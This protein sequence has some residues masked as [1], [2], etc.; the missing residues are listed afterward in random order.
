MQQMLQQEQQ[1]YQSLMMDKQLEAQ[2]LQIDQFNAETNRMKAAKEVQ[3]V[4][5]IQ[6][7]TQSD[8]TEAEKMRFD[9][10]VKFAL[11]EQKQ[12]GAIELELVKQRA[13]IAKANTDDMMIAD[14]NL[15]LVPSGNANAIV[16]ALS[17]LSQ[18][19]ADLKRKTSAPKIIIRDEKGRA[20][21]SRIVEDEE[22]DSTDD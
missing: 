15:N 21:G 18:N 22:D 10:E 8:M 4:Q 6:D 16:A 9:A 5:N 2:K 12:K 1:K 11:E 13:D 14:E 7:V 17:E 20:V 3:P 19:M